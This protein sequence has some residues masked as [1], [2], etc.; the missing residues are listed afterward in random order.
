MNISFITPAGARQI[1]FESKLNLSEEASR[2][3]QINNIQR[4]P[5]EEMPVTKSEEML[6]IEEIGRL[7]MLYLFTEITLEA[8]DYIALPL[9]RDLK[10]TFPAIS[11]IVMSPDHGGFEVSLET[12][13]Q[14][15][16]IGHSFFCISQDKQCAPKLLVGVYQEEIQKKLDV[17][18]FLKV[19][20]QNKHNLINHRGY[21]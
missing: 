8:M 7:S 20:N 16:K 15:R 1:L 9:I 5:D 11:I 19:F 4:S 18:A 14:L 12:M 13:A 2:W 10:R 17:S 6:C 21:C 3:E